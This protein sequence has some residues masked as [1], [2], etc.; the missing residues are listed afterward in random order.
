[1]W[2]FLCQIQLWYEEYFVWCW[3][4]LVSLT[5]ASCS[6]FTI[7]VLCYIKLSWSPPTLMFYLALHLHICCPSR[8]LYHRLHFHYSGD[9]TALWRL[10]QQHFDCSTARSA[11]NYQLLALY[12]EIH[13]WLVDSPSKG[14]YCAILWRHHSL[15]DILL[16]QMKFGTLLTAG[17]QHFCHADMWHGTYYMFISWCNFDD[18]RQ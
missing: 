11:N 5:Y 15:F 12:W 7:C 3:K 6:R 4:A 9:I 1:M 8:Q 14:Q 18:N 16:I 2:L 13:W 17:L 10:N